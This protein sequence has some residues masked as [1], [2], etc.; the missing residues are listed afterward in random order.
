M[1][2]D[3]VME[4][5]T[6]RQNTRQSIDMTVEM[7][8]YGFA[9]ARPLYVAGNFTMGVDDE[10]DIVVSPVGESSINSHTFV[11]GEFRF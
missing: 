9:M 3:D 7:R 10:G 8:V 4:V 11:N 6:T 2:F 1:T 5:W